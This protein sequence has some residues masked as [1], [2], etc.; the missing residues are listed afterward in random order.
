MDQLLVRG[1]ARFT[2]L[3]VGQ[4]S[5]LPA[6][7]RMPGLEERLG[8]KCL[9]RHFTL[10]E[11]ISYVNHRLTAAGAKQTIFEPDAVEA[12]HH[13]SG[14]VARKINRLCD[15][16]L[17][18]GYAEEQSMIAAAQIESVSDELVTVVPD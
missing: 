2:L 1:T 7:D 5:L 11:S 9:L 12:L 10:E 8:V 17:L 3:L 14:G 6:L 18:I 15:L 16:A 4:P 13:L